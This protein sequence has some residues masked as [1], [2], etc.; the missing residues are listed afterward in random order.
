MRVNDQRPGWLP[1]RVSQF[2]S[3]LQSTS[4][5]LLSRCRSPSRSQSRRASHRGVGG[6]RGW[7]YLCDESVGRDDTTLLAQLTELTSR[8]DRHRLSLSKRARA[9]SLTI[10]VCTLSVCS[11]V[12]WLSLHSAATTARPSVRSV[13][14]SGA[15]IALYTL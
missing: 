4:P 14:S 15:V 8:T 7:S 1:P 10:A 13:A 12:A 5:V 3:P 6:A 11:V 9:L 2:H